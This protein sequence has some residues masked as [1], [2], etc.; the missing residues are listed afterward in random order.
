MDAVLGT[1]YSY[2]VAAKA[3][4]Q[5]AAS[6]VG[7]IEKEKVLLNG[8]K[9]TAKYFN[10]DMTKAILGIAGVASMTGS[11]FEDISQVF[12]R[13]AGQGRVM[14]N[15]LNSISAR[16]LNAAAT[17]AKYLDKTEAEVRDM[18]TKGQID[19]KT[20][21]AA[22]TDAF[23]EHAK[24]STQTFMGALEDV[25][26]ALA[27][28][29]ADFYGPYLTA[30]RDILNSLTPIVD[31]VHD[32]IQPALDLAGKTML[33]YSKKATGYLDI[34]T[35]AGNTLTDNLGNK[36]TPELNIVQKGI[37]AIHD[38]TVDLE[39]GPV[40]AFKILGDHL[41]ITAKEAKNLSEQGKISFT[42]FYDA[43]S[44]F[45]SS[46][47]EGADSVKAYLA[48]MS[49]ELRRYENIADN[50]GLTQDK[51]TMAFERTAKVM[52]VDVSKVYEAVG[53]KL[54][55][56]GEELEKAAKKGEV[57]LV[58]F[59]RA[60]TDLVKDG[61]MTDEQFHSIMVDIDSMILPI[62]KLHSAINKFGANFGSY[63]TD[64]IKAGKDVLNLFKDAFKG[65]I[66]VLNGGGGESA[67]FALVK[68]ILAFVAA[69]SRGVSK[70]IEL[71]RTSGVF[72]KLHDFLLS[73][74]D[75]L[76]GVIDSL[77]AFGANLEIDFTSISESLG[78][79]LEPILNL[80]K[81]ITSFI[82]GKTSQ[83]I[84]LITQGFSK[85][86]STLS[87]GLSVISK[88]GEAVKG[89]GKAIA[90]A[91]GLKMLSQLSLF[92][93][94]ITKIVDTFRKYGVG[95]FGKLYASFFKFNVGSSTITALNDGLWELRDTIVKFQVAINARVLSL[96]ATAI[97]ELA[98]A[99]KILSDIPAA[100]LAASVTAIEGL[101]Q[102][103]VLA[104][105]SLNAAQTQGIIKIAF[106]I[107]ILASAM[108]VLSELSVGGIAK[109]LAAIGALMQ[110]L[111]KMS[112]YMSVVN[113]GNMN[114]VAGTLVLYA[115][116]LRM[117]VKP[118]KQIGEMKL[119]DI[120]KGLAAVAVTLQLLSKTAMSFSRFKPGELLKA[121]G[122]MILF[123][124]AINEL[125]IPIELLGHMNV[126]NLGK[127]LG[128]IA[129]IL[130][131]LG[132]FTKAMTEVGYMGLEMMALAPA[133]MGMAKALVIMGAAL[134]IMGNTANIGTGLS[135][136]F[137][138]LLIL[139]GAMYAMQK[140]LPGAVAMIAVA[141]ALAIIAPPLALL[142]SLSFG[143]VVT[144]LIALAGAIFIF[145]KAAF[146]LTAAW[147][148]FLPG[149]AILLA[150][151][152]AVALL[153]VG[154]MALGS[155]MM[156]LAAAF[157]T[158]TDSII[159]GLTALAAM[160]PTITG[161]LWDFIKGML[162]GFIEAAPL[163]VQ[164]ITVLIDSLLEAVWTNVPK[165]AKVGLALI[166]ALMQAIRD[167][168]GEITNLA[169]DIIT[170]FVNALASRAGD[171]ATA[172][173]W[174][175]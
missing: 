7:V 149:V 19:F 111:V 22:M 62:G 81:A 119:Q 173:A 6:D 115:L 56:T 58:D 114:K 137:S 169:I 160:L 52:G 40:N 38:S 151:S 34:I 132:L 67:L 112:L 98:V 74:N 91:F 155:G 70:L 80:F 36:L 170:N 83:G 138:S 55:K 88:T 4:S 29:G 125:V 63:F 78:K 144:G 61:A 14:S 141:A 21:S 27:R 158:G 146:I 9:A 75:A 120:V 3:A 108:K 174:A 1:A 10:E 32:R 90:A 159:E 48:D 143:G 20:F 104:T 172:G 41:G 167:K 45:A 150:L 50:L 73:V 135:V 87:G 94:E 133:L 57:S 46:G 43:M 100:R 64:I 96:I 25:K 8:T 31:L 89:I 142:S 2:D 86:I 105:R 15:D 175:C 123:G 77:Y 127:G 37:K 13:V 99:V 33:K 165:M 30:A 42:D 121:A 95:G 126:K 157:K 162:V 23:G 71:G 66:D 85:L 164:S 35:V 130:L 161:Y 107:R 145:G 109:G 117:M 65:L 68:T 18:V 124:I 60:L 54:G 39:N 97:L 51:M 171:L 16:G 154:I 72:K 128:A 110:M 106:A 122:S 92:T 11:S 113:P 5:L 24:D 166:V 136:M 129:I 79:L 17:L 84:N 131:E 44:K 147:E 168:I 103:L 53:E 69:L 134:A 163:I 139:A 148:F 118:I 28:I 26:A 93:G 101:M 59:R 12:T 76:F 152:A 82:G 102:I 153:G 47:K 116:A 49:A 156:M 140:A